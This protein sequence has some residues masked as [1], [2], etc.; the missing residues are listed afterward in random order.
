MRRYG[1]I[2]IYVLNVPNFVVQRQGERKMSYHESYHEMTLLE[3]IPKKH[4]YT[5]ISVSRETRPHYK[6]TGY[7]GHWVS[8]DESEIRVYIM[9][10]FHLLEYISKLVQSSEPRRGMRNEEM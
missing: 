3:P 6:T 9:R 4:I 1:L 8:S 7:V 2:G 10:G 5:T